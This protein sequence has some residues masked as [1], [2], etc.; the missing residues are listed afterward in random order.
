M[1]FMYR[2][3]P[4]GNAALPDAADGINTDADKCCG[5]IR[6]SFG[7]ESRLYKFTVSAERLAEV[8]VAPLVG[9]VHVDDAL[10]RPDPVVLFG[11]TGLPLDAAEVDA[12]LGA[13]LGR[14]DGQARGE[15]GP[16]DGDLDGPAVVGVGGVVDGAVEGDGGLEAG[17]VPGVV[18][19]AVLAVGLVE[20][21]I[22]RGVERVDLELEVAGSSGG[23][24]EEDFEV[25]VVEDD[26]VVLGELGLDVGL[27]ELGADVEVGVVPEHLHAGAEARFGLGVA[28][29]VD[30]V[31]GPLAFFHAA[32]SSLPSMVRGFLARWQS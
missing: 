32:S 23:R 30:E 13:L 20:V 1:R 11:L 16:G 29:D 6:A 9:D 25:V 15:G 24:L 17:D 27:F 21:E 3:A 2:L 10:R 18:G 19:L 12:P 4:C 8:E 22:P 26:G 31:I 14:F 5:D 28:F 7:A